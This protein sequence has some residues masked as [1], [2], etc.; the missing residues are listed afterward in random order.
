MCEYGSGPFRMTGIRLPLDPGI[1]SLLVAKF[2]PYSASMSYTPDLTL[3]SA[4]TRMV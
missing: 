3:L 2:G 4:I 1:V